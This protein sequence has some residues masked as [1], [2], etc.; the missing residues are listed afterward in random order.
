MQKLR[1]GNGVLANLF[2]VSAHGTGKAHATSPDGAERI[3]CIIPDHCND[4]LFFSPEK[5]TIYIWAIPEGTEN[6]KDCVPI[7]L[8]IFF[9][10]FIGKKEFA[11]AYAHLT[12]G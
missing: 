2:F 6:P 8:Q 10:H 12:C 1:K 9:V 3:C 5:S 11:L 4:L 7:S